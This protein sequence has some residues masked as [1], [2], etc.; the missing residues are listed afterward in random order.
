MRNAALA[1]IPFLLLAGCSLSDSGAGIAGT[2][3]RFTEIDGAPPVSKSAQ[4]SFE[5]DSLGASVGC[6]S[7]G[8]EWR[9]ENDRL[10]AGPL[11]QTEM[12]CAE[13]L[14]NQEKALNSLLSSAPVII[15]E[16]DRM[17]L[18]SHGRSAELRK[19]A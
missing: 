2:N 3:W 19:V 13:P 11:T 14:W 17:T 5:R 12:Y 18:R 1:S 10:I 4:I 16:G 8:G 15:V 6:N 9:V 7:M